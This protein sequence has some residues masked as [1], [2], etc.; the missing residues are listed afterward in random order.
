MRHNYFIKAIAAMVVSL[1]AVTTMA[2]GVHEQVFRIEETMVTVAENTGLATRTYLPVKDG[3]HPTVLIRTTYGSENMAW[4]AEYLASH[5]YAVVVQDVR[6]MNGSEGTFFPFAYDKADGMATLAWVMEQPFF[7]G[8]VGLWGISYLGFAA[9]EIAS[10]G[11]PAIK[12]MF[13]LSGWSDVERFIMPSGSFHL[14]AHLP[15]FMIFQ[16][17]HSPPAEAWPQI[18]RATPIAQFFQGADEAMG[19]MMSGPYDYSGFKMPIM[20]VTGWYDYIYPDTLHTY[21]SVRKVPDAAEQRLIVG[22]WPHN[23]ALNGQSVAGDEDFGPK[24]AWGIEKVNETS[25]RWFDLHL[26]GQD[27]GLS[28]EPPVRLFVMGSNEWRDFDAWPP[29]TM[30]PQTWSTLR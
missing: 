27:D 5:G 8:D 16:G 19:Q 28:S 10:T 13:V 9:N 17:G 2:A 24:A 29:R 21:E 26:K 11:H 6:G 18:Y 23:N 4:A 14:M 22:V 1:A 20:H 30:K 3:K 12:A 7:N 25:R 15:W